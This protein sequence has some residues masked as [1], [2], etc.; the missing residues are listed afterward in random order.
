MMSNVDVDLPTYYVRRF[1]PYNVQYLGAFLEPLPTL[2]SD[3]IYGRSLMEIGPNLTQRS[4][5][6]LNKRFLPRPNTTTA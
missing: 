6:D 5:I 2:I 1:L 4:R 3:V